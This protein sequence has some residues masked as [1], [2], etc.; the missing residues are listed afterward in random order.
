MIPGETPDVCRE[1]NGERFAFSQSD[2]DQKKS[3]NIFSHLEHLDFL[4]IVSELFS[5]P[6]STSTHLSGKGQAPAQ[7]HCRRDFYRTQVYL[8]SDLWVAS[9]SNWVTLPLVQYK[10]YKLYKSYNLY[11]LYNLYKLYNLYNLYKL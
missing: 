7:S 11:N 4:K 5:H 10:L 8:G 1:S 2:K 3:I 6:G 9:V